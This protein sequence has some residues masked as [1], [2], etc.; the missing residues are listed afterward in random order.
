MRAYREAGY[1]HEAHTDNRIQD[2]LAASR[3]ELREQM[4]ELTDSVKTPVDTAV[5]QYTAAA[6]ELPPA[7]EI[8]VQ[9]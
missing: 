2:H 4:R 5:Q 6:A 3:L 8:S 9:A 7:P 1:I